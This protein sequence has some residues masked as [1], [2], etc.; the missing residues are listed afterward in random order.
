[1]VASVIQYNE[2]GHPMEVIRPADPALALSE[3][4]EIIDQQD[5]GTITYD[6]AMRR[7]QVLP[8]MQAYRHVGYLSRDGKRIVD[9]H[10]NYSK[11]QP[12]DSFV[13][14]AERAS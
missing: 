1:M 4:R 13:T 10:G 11:M 3:A 5:D 2:D 8:Q 6:E 9:R 7:F 14:A 12:G